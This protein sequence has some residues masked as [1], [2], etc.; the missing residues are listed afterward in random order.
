MKKTSPIHHRYIKV[1]E[2]SEEDKCY[3]G[4]CPGLMFGGIHGQDEVAV[5]RELCVAAEE[6]IELMKKSGKPLPPGTIKKEYSGTFN[7]RVAPDVHKALAI[8]AATRGESLNAYCEKVLAHE[9]GA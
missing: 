8:R 5:Y 7:L 9:I 1:V 3:I 2:W 4:T 6:V